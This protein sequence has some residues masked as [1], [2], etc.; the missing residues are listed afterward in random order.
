MSYVDVKN[1]VVLDNPAPFL[2][3]FRF[4][5]TFDCTGTLV[6]GI[7]PRPTTFPAPYLLALPTAFPAPYVLALPTAFPAPYLLALP[8]ALPAP[9][10]LALTHTLTLPES[11]SLSHLQTWSGRSSMSG[12]RRARTTTRCSTPSL[13]ARFP[14][15]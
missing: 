5:I 6:D 9:Y 7:E 3:Q 15:A 2:A 4:E 8:T 1:I 12:Q 10:L 13:S 14:L 11:P